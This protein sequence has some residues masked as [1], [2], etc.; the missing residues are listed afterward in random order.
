MKICC[1][2]T[3]LLFASLALGGTPWK[4]KLSNPNE[5][6]DFH[7][8]LHNESIEVPGMEVLGRMHGYLGGQGVYGVWMVTSFKVLSPQEARIRLSNDLGSETQ[9]IRLVQQTDSTYLFEQISGT[10]IKRVVNRK[11]VKIPP[12]LVFTNK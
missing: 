1:F 6:I 5:K 11:L 3:A 7:I 8:N 12:K 9:T 10:T 4:L 2:I